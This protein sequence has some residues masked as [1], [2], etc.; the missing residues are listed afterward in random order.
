MRG[1]TKRVALASVSG[2]H[3]GMKRREFCQRLAWGAGAFLGAKLLGATS[4]NPRWKLGLGLNGFASGERKYDARYP[5][6]EVL[7]FAT[8]IGFEGIEL[9]DGW[10][11]GAYPEV[12]ESRRV[13][14]L[15]NL[16]DR[17]GLS[18]FSLQVGAGGAFDPDP[19]KR[20]DWLR[21][22]R[23]RALLANA[24]GAD[25]VGLW[26]GGGLRGQSL[27]EALKHLAETFSEA[28][29]LGGELGLTVA[30]EIEPPFVFNSEVHLTEI[31]GQSN[32]GLK[33]IYDPSHFDLM[34]GSSGQPEAMLKRIGVENIGYVHLTDTDGT[35]R[36]GGTSKHLACG[37][38]HLNIG[39]SLEVLCEGGFSGWIMIDGW[40][41]PDPF[42]AARK[43]IQ[44]IKRGQRDCV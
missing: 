39:R 27:K 14:A 19:M 43:G 12:N 1:Q 41:V 42:D 7:H 31:L 30:F 16:Y 13:K 32:N 28:A 29:A 3:D 26:P 9:V 38:G 25:C 17:Y 44:A 2:W 5:L 24:L 22:F 11:S 33:T 15:R 36:D 10:P 40:E 6:W 8:E 23:Q 34:N 21:S 35:L 37:D 18:V 4:L 20:R